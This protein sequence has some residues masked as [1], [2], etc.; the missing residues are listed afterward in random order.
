MSDQISTEATVDR[1]R[2]IETTLE[3]LAFDTQNPPG[4]TDGIVDYLD[5]Q[6]TR[7]GL[8]TAQLHCA[9]NKPNLVAWFG[10]QREPE[11][12]FQGHVDTVPFDRAAWTVDPLGEQDGETVYGRGSTD[13][14]GA[15]AAM[16]ETARLYAD[17]DADP[18]V[19]LGFA[20]VSDEEVS[21][22]DTGVA[23]LDLFDSRPAACVIG[24]QTGTPERLSVTVADKGAIWL[25]LAATGTAA[26]GSR[27]VLGDNA[28][29][30]I[31]TAV[32]RLRIELSEIAF[33]LDPALDEILAD[34]VD[35]YAS[36]MGEESAR[37][38]F[39]QPTLNLGMLSGGEAINSVPA[40]A[41]AGVDI[42]L[43]AS[44]STKP[45]V[46]RI[47][48]IINE[49]PGVEI[50]SVDW[51]EGTYE[52]VDAPLVAATAEAASAVTGRRVFRR[53]ATGGGDAKTL[54]NAGISIVEFALG[55]ETAHAVDER[56]TVEALIG[57]AGVYTRLPSM[58]AGRLP[59]DNPR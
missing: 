50:E 38:L 29:D 47:R 35:Y 4:E 11:L 37:E 27:P 42:R 45:V 56:T 55:T 14:K 9:P 5:D 10:G 12:V 53:S 51:S 13:M 18:P 36:T 15:V 48:S 3:L 6:L 40:S 23:A 8:E 21:G 49:Q 24:E 7:A 20:F 1:T 46:D 2:L 41:T 52:P 32:D 22:D 25:R 19:P 16:V 31:Y 57:T 54:R 44:V 43:T 39:E 26:H 33:D 28:L 17:G 58:L 59:A 34:S 30:R